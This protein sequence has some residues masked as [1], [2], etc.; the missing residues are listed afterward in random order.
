MTA[1]Q[2]AIDAH[3][4]TLIPAPPERI[5]NCLAAL[6]VNTAR[7]NLPEATWARFMTTLIA[8][9]ANTPPNI[10][11]AACREWRHREVF[12]PR[13]TNLLALIRSPLAK[14]VYNLKR[15]HMIAAIA[16]C[17]TP[18]T[19]P[20]WDWLIAVW[21]KSGVVGADKPAGDNHRPRSAEASGAK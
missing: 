12:F 18:A 10:L 6:A 5:A 19:G 21:R 13:A 15:L 20:N 9:L 3:E 16:D 1:T 8:D 7:P 14:R 17:P 4:R 11:D 2:A